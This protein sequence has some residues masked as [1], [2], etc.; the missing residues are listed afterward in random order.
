M[1][2][3]DEGW[4]SPEVSY[5]PV[6][7]RTTLG[8]IFVLT[9]GLVASEKLLDVLSLTNVAAVERLEVWR[10]L[11]YGFTFDVQGATVAF[12]F[13]IMIW[14]YWFGRELETQVG[15]LKLI[16]I[17]LSTTVLGGVSWVLYQYVSG[18]ASPAS[19]N[20]MAGPCALMMAA[21]MFH[22][23]KSVRYF[24][25]VPTSLLVAALLSIAVVGIYVSA[26]YKSATAATPAAVAVVLTFGLFRLSPL[27]E[28]L[29]ER[30][31]ARWARLRA[32]RED[33]LR[34]EVDGILDKISRSG[35][36]SL[37]RYELKLL[38][39][40]SRALAEKYRE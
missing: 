34:R 24:F 18:S 8:L 36:A 1:S 38:K 4:G 23:K 3:W 27:F 22:P 29:A 15:G 9:L 17:F 11:T 40:A 31:A 20:M 6:R 2:D 39:R 35:M 25:F 14:T 10:L 19:G 13:I 26:H 33:E 12:F 16:M 32:S 5:R 28:R 30:L 21:A 37:S 7:S